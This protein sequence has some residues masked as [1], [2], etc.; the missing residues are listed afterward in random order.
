MG[1][2]DKLKGL[3]LEDKGDGKNAEGQ[4]GSKGDNPAENPAQIAAEKSAASVL[5]SGEETVTEKGGDVEKMEHALQIAVDSLKRL[6]VEKSRLFQRRIKEF[7]SRRYEKES[8]AIERITNLPRS[9]TGRPSLT[10]VPNRPVGLNFLTP[11]DLRVLIADQEFVFAEAEGF[12]SSSETILK[13]D[14]LVKL[15]E[16]DPSKK[17]EVDKVIQEATQLQKDAES[18]TAQ[19]QEEIQKLNSAMPLAEKRAEEESK[20]IQSYSQDIHDGETENWN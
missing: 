11:G 1:F 6:S 12:K 15:Q 18:M 19:A 13:D 4:N 16:Q 14:R 2:R 17:S 10:E 7:H 20:L 8:A 9:I 3:F 5:A